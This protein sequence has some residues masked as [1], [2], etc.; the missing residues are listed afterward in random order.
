MANRFSKLRERMSPAR[1]VRVAA[2]AA[3]IL[4]EMPLQELRQARQ[5]SQETLADDL[6][7]QEF[8]E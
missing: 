8:A 7:E 1:K 3:Q 4:E 2:R 6:C 5:Y